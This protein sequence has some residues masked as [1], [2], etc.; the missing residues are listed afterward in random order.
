MTIT[1]I[2][3]FQDH[4]DLEPPPEAL[5]R[6]GRPVSE[7]QDLAVYYYT[8][9]GAREAG[10]DEVCEAVLALVRRRPTRHAYGVHT[11]ECVIP[12]FSW[13]VEKTLEQDVDRIFMRLRVDASKEYMMGAITSIA[14]WSR[15]AAVAR[16]FTSG[17]TVRESIWAAAVSKAQL[18][19]PDV[20]VKR[21]WREMLDRAQLT[22]RM[23]GFIPFAQ[24]C[25]CSGIVEFG[26]HPIPGFVDAH[27]RAES[28]SV[29]PNLAK[30]ETRELFRRYVPPPVVPV[31]ISTR[32]SNTKL[33]LVYSLMGG[34]TTTQTTTQSPKKVRRSPPRTYPQPPPVEH[35]DS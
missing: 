14:N 10:K 25:I 35:E 3:P 24:M 30:D 11:A 26:G 23:T 9:D 2:R 5:T 18:E 4:P 19:Y 29:I 8:I 34:Q 32:D 28:L 22:P 6:E 31:D 7:V 15:G 12:F 27:F 17:L 13:V 33:S 21:T 20:Q 16:P 1:M